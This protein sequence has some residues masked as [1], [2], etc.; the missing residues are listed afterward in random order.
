MILVSIGLSIIE[1]FIPFGV[2][3]S[4]GISILF[5]VKGSQWSWENKTWSSV[6]EFNKSHEA[7][8]KAGLI[9]FIIGI[10]LI[11]LSA[12]A[13]IGGLFTIANSVI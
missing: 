6:E 2:V 3:I 11:I 9:V 10:F 4:I 5:G 1:Y 7:W 13:L 8:N 12:I